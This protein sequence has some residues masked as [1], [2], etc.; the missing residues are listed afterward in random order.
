[1]MQAVIFDMDG[2]LVNSEPVHKK[3][4]RDFFNECGIEISEGDHQ[5]YV[6]MTMPAFYGELK[7]K[8]GLSGKVEDFIA[9]HKKLYLEYLMQGRNVQLMPGVVDLIQG[10]SARGMKLALATSALREV[11]EGVMRSFDLGQYFSIKLCSDDV[12]NGK[13]DPEI[14]LRASEGLEVP[15]PGCLVF[16][17]A[18]NGV[19]AAK[20]AGM[21]CI[22]YTFFGKNPQDLSDADM[23]IDDYK[24]ITVDDFGSL[25]S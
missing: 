11:M 4:E 24:K 14:F 7:E 13:P 12:V 16:E 2:T 8:F 18:V 25:W 23:M 21:K 20:S 17:D 5:A 9:S 10:F 1:M 3:I 19:R 22:G 6:G 15:S